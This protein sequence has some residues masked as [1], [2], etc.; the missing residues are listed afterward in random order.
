M[1]SWI[2]RPV[3]AAWHWRWLL[4]MNLY[5]LS[6]VLLYEFRVG[7]GGPDRTI[8]FIL[9]ASVLSLVAA[10]LLARRVWVVHA[11]LFPLYLVVATDLYVI[12]HYHTRLSSS[13]LLTVFENLEDSR[14]YAQIHGPWMAAQLALVL[15]GYAFCMAKIRHLRIR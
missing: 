5:L 14:E 11:L 8:L 13:M 1:G 3:R 6:P 2:E 9:S 10:Q 12:F 15:A 7:E 4:V